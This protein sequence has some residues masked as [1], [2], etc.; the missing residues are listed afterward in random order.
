L[1]ALDT[2]IGR[3]QEDHDHIMQIARGK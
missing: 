1:V 3:L 2:M